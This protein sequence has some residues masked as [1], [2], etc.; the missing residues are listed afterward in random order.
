MIISDR[1]KE[2]GILVEDDSEGD[3]GDYLRIKRYWL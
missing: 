1:M 2:L 3:L